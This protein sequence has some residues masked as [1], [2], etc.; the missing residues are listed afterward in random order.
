MGYSIGIRVKSGAAYAKMLAFMSE[1]Y[2]PWTAV[3]G[4]P[5]G[6]SFASSPSDDLAYDSRGKLTLG[7]DYGCVLDWE[8]EHIYVILR[9]MAIKVG[10]TRR[11]FRKDSVTPSTLDEPVPYIVYDGYDPWPVLVGTKEEAK[12]LPSTLRQFASDSLGLRNG[13]DALAHLV[14]YLTFDPDVPA[15]AAQAAEKVARAKVGPY[16][17]KGDRHAWRRRYNRALTGQPAFRKVLDKKLK[18]LRAD[19]ERLDRAWEAFQL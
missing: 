9:W 15:E 1:H 7:F 19:L 6:K 3:I 16:P 11:S 18:I 13:P 8:R 2:R 10:R 17:E 4:H 5:D 14:T 12:R